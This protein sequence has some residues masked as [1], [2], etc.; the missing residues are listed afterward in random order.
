M[1]DFKLPVVNQDASR[2]CGP[3]TS[4]C[5][6][7]LTANIKGHEMHPG[8][9]CFF[10]A[11]GKCTDYDGRPGTC[12][13]YNCSWKN[14]STVF[15]AWM[16]PDLSG[17]IVTKVVL[18]MRDDLTHY[19]VAEARGKLDVKT[20]N[21][22]VQWALEKGHNLFYEIDGKHHAIGSTEFKDGMSGK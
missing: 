22:L 6:G 10:L 12:K 17:V 4:C 5:E 15:P 19:E 1:S 20:L 13:S 3:C 14:E 11:D 2:R 9:P 18:P 7:W 16:R 8:R 21:W